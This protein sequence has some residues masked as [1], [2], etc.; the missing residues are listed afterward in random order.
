MKPSD[1]KI[2]KSCTR[3]IKQDIR[4]HIDTNAR[5]KKKQKYKPAYLYVADMKN[6]LFI[7]YL[8]ISKLTLS[9][10]SFNQRNGCERSYWILIF[11]KYD[12]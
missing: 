10:T 11:L 1:K 9:S 3:V 4:T 6:V 5:T 2:Y 7:T 12:A 8:N